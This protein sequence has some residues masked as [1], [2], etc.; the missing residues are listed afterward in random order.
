[1]RIINLPIRLDVYL[2]SNNEAKGQ[3]YL[4]DGETFR[5]EKNDERT[6]IEFTFRDNILRSRAVLHESYYDVAS[7]III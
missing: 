1:M 3:I 6:L 4:D 7:E 5:F 2:N